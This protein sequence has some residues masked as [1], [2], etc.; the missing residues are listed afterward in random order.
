MI[1][2]QQRNILVALTASKGELTAHE[3]FIALNERHSLASISVALDRMHKAKLVNRRKG[4]PLPE[5]GGK[6]RQYYEITLSGRAALL[7]A[8][9]GSVSLDSMQSAKLVE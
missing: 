5:R 4:E 8:D 3:I 6:A 2:W 1:G 9:Q 7:E